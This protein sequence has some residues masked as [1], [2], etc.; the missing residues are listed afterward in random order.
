MHGR[1][2]PSTALDALIGVSGLRGRAIEATLVA[3]AVSTAV[4]AWVE[5]RKPRR[6][7]KSPAQPVPWRPQPYGERVLVF[8]TETTTDAAQRLLFGFFRLYER[9]RLIL[10]GIIVADVLDYEQMMTIAEYAANAACRSTAAS[11]LWKRSSI[12]RSTS[13]AR[14]AS[15]STCRL[16]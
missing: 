1:S 13:R 15:A 3:P 11:G 5:P 7:R 6:W 8:D 9:D 2:R 14:S 4:R 10:E 16:I 12:P